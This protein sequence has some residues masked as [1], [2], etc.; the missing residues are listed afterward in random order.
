MSSLNSFSFILS[1][2]VLLALMTVLQMPEK[3]R[4]GAKA[5]PVL[6]RKPAFYI[7]VIQLCIFMPY[8][9]PVWSLCGSRNG[10]CLWNSSD[11]FKN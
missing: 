7:A 1:L 9:Y 10:C 3:A 5:S 11:T 4:G 8:R 2:A 6:Q